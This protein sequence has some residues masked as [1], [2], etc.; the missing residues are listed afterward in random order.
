MK[1]LNL[2][3]SLILLFFSYSASA[4][5]MTEISSPRKQLSNVKRLGVF[6][7]TFD[8][9]H[10]A[11]EEM[12]DHLLEHNLVD[13]V[14]IGAND[15]LT[16]KPNAS[17]WVVRNRFL[18]TTYARH[19][20]VIVANDSSKGFPIPANNVK[21]LR[22]QIHG[23][24]VHAIMGN[25]VATIPDLESEI[26]KNIMENGGQVDL[27]L[28]NNSRPE[29]NRSDAIPQKIA[30]IDVLV[31]QTQS[32]LSSSG[33]R[34]SIKKDSGDLGKVEDQLNSQVIKLIERDHLYV[35]PNCKTLL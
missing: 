7:G 17:S 10:R 26:S 15:N 30:G 35:S 29:L 19:P 34:R 3:L 21:A 33:I 20:K 6:I 31:F 28:V 5:L 8:P 22:Q 23:A 2:S 14:I 18:T 16:H 27:W 25:D 11:H 32:G 13:V 12:I 4:I 24:E 1:K 9:L